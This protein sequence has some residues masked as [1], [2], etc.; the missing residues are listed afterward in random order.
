MND[1]DKDKINKEY[2]EN[3]VQDENQPEGPN[4]QMIQMI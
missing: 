2:K 3:K 1:E 4:L